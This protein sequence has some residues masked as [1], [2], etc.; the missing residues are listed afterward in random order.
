MDKFKARLYFM[1]IMVVL[2]GMFLVTTAGCKVEKKVEQV[3][4]FTGIRKAKRKLY[5]RKKAKTA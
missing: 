2:F 3:E 1:G 4:G 5:R